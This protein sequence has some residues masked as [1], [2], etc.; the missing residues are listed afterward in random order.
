MGRMRAW[1][2]LATTVAALVVFATAPFLAMAG[3][4]TTS[5]DWPRYR[6]PDQNGISRERLKPWPAA[7]PKQLWK[8][9]VGLG[10]SSV[11]VV[12]GRVY[13]MGNTNEKDTIFCLQAK[14]GKVLWKHTYPCPP[15]KDYF[16]TRATPT[17]H[18]G[19]VYTLSRE[20]QAY[21]LS[22]K[23]G[24]VVWFRNL[25]ADLGLELPGWGFASSALILNHMVIFNLGEN[26][27]ALDRTSGEIIWSSEPA[28]AGYAEAVP[29]LMHDTQA[30]AVFSAK[31]LYGVNAAN[32][33][34]L[35]S[36]LWKTSW[37]VNAAT[38]IIVDDKVFISSDYG[39]G[40]VLL[41]I[42][43]DEPEEIWRTKKMRN[44]FGTC[45]LWNK[46]L[47]GN[48]QGNLRCID[49]ETGAQRWAK[50]GMGRGQVIL[51]GG[52]LLYMTGDGELVLARATPKAYEEHARAQVLGGTCWSLPVLS[53][54]RIYCRNHE[55]QLVCLKAG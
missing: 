14:T 12:G 52:D 13:T 10:Y 32:G 27:V 18:A 30:V 54:G 2:L 46:Y 9:E 4:N 33:E 22:A 43:G 44:H 5:H 50:D 55:G 25:K 7:G 20:G 1:I 28:K 47:Y 19:K 53:H 16:G 41:N 6:G 11:A 15:G 23:T 37:D 42:S 49:F 39:N 21:C 51:A 36:Y 24:K 35:W 34:I 31:K 40:G 3:K 26:G 48:D 38:P 29:F 17:V 8:T 45:V